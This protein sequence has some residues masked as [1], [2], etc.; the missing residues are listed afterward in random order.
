MMISRHTLAAVSKINPAFVRPMI[1]FFTIL[2]RGYARLDI[3]VW[4]SA[5]YTYIYISLRYIYYYF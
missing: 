3:S 5:F 2:L 4:R 1:L